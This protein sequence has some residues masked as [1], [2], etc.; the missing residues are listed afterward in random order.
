ME[1]HVVCFI[2]GA[3]LLG[4]GLVG[5]GVTVKDLSLPRVSWFSRLI[6]FALGAFL[7]VLGI[8]LS[9]SVMN[10]TNIKLFSI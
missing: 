7:M 8:S 6:S 3:I 1:I 4:V 9:P 5:G 2:F 10:S